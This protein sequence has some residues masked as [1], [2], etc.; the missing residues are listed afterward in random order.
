MQEPTESLEEQSLTAGGRVGLV[1][2]QGR[3]DGRREKGLAN[4]RIFSPGMTGLQP[5]NNG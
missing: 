2:V 3:G 5:R 1:I 4:G